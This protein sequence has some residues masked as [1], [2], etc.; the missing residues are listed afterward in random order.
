MNAPAADGGNAPPLVLLEYPSE[1]VARITLNRPDKRNAMNRAAR[2]ALLDALDRC[3]GTARVI[4]LTGNGPAFC[5]GIDLKEANDAPRGGNALDGDSPWIAVQEAIRRHPAIVIA[6]VNGFALG[7]GVTLINVSDLAFASDDAQ[8]GMPEVGFGL[9][10]GLA[11]PSTQLRLS[12]KRAAWMVLTGERI[13]GRVAEEWGLVNRSVTA[14]SLQAEALALAVRVA[15]H[16]AVTLEWCKKALWE[17]PMHIGDWTA[18]LEYGE[19]VGIQIRARTDAV[20]RGIQAFAAGERSP[21]QGAHA[22]ADAAEGR[23]G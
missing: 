20:G 22:A 18:A 6:A 17:V 5:A 4:I 21:G 13:S 1:N 3:R 19:G 12:Q 23:N 16:D 7:G 8:I 2:A 10:P 15:E 14:E 11:G 9:Y